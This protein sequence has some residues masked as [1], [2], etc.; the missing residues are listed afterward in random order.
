MTKEALAKQQQSITQVPDYLRGRLGDRV[1]SENVTKDDLL[2]PRLGVAQ[3]LSP[4]LKK[5]QDGYIPGLEVGD[6][7]NTV[8]GEVYGKEVTV[9]PLFF[10]RNFIEFKP[11]EEGG[12]V[13]KMYDRVED[14]PLT[15]LAFIDGKKPKVTEFKSRVCLLVQDGR[16]PE[17]IVVSFKSSGMK[18]ARKWNS[19][20][21][22]LDLPAYARAY[23]LEA[24]TRVKGQQEWEGLNVLPL[25]FVPQDFFLAAERMFNELKG[26][27]VRIDTTGL[28]DEQ[29]T[30]EPVPF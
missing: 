9:V 4:Q 28:V 20:I 15:D 25:D 29:P 21:Q 18:T 10:L 24:V 19:L 30:A 1:G 11:I 13:V 7:F 22:M 17:P 26:Q 16:G 8:T 12:G 27:G 6:L 23:R 14:V 3:S 2:I 5:S